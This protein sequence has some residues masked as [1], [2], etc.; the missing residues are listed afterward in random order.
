YTPVGDYADFYLGS[1]RTHICNLT[2]GIYNLR[3]FDPY[4]DGVKINENITIGL[5]DYFYIYTPIETQDCRLTLFN[6]DNNH[7]EFTDYHITVNRS[8][9]GVYDD[10]SLLDNLFLVDIETYIYIN[11]SDRF[12]T[13]IDTFERLSSDFIDLE[14]EVYSLQI[15]NIMEIKTTVD[16]NTTHIYPLLFGESVHFMLSKAYYQ[17]KFI[18]EYDY[19][20]NFTIYLDSNQAYQ[21]NSSLKTIYFSMFTYDGLGIDHDLVRFYINSERKDLGFNSMLKDTLELVILDFFNNTL[22]NETID[23]NAYDNSEYNLFVEIYSLVILNQFT[24]EDIVVNITQ[25]GSGVWMTQVIPKQF[26]LTYRFLPNVEYNITIYFTN[27]TLYTSKIINLTT[28]SHIESF[29]V[30]T[31]PEEYPKNIYFGVYTTTGLGI[32]R[33]LLRFYIDGNRTDFGFNR[34]TDMI[35]T[36]VVKDY[37][38]TTLFNQMINTSGIY[39]YDILI[40]LYSLKVKNEA[41]VTASYTLSYGVLGTSGYIF[42]EEIIEYQLS[43]NNYVFDYTNNEDGSFHTININL[44][45]DRVYI[46]NTTYYDVYIGLYNFYG[47]V[48]KEEVKFYIDGIRADFG[49]NTI[50]SDSVD[51]LVLDYFNSILYSQT[52]TL[53]GLTEYSIFIQAYTLV[54]N[55]LYNEKP[56]TIK[57]TRGS[58][59]IERLI[60]AQGWTE[61]KLYPNIRYDISSF[62][63]GTKDED[64][65]VDLKEEYTVVDFGFYE[66]EVPK[67]PVPQFLEAL[68]QWSMAI[69]FIAIVGIIGIVVYYKINSDKEK[70]YREMQRQIQ[71][72]R[73]KSFLNQYK[74]KRSK[75]SSRKKAKERQRRR[76]G[77]L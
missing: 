42:P 2:S 47:I 46:L 22:A 71:N 56:I 74:E 64:N 55:N 60:E 31:L 66:T 24:Y 34:I 5:S 51:L 18:D 23:A 38:N 21:L 43:S 67:Y 41:R 14:L 63:N 52:V 7:L 44:N 40:T 25:V 62:I 73:S 12:D 75:M 10:F 13:L 26:G 61:F 49:F 45:Q 54:V 37:F 32:D 48:N 28:N 77:L 11:V 29:G 15:K 20:K 9:N 36:I 65:D 16:I 69:V 33:D 8:L 17:I 27:T 53:Q 50:T 70:K 19:Y 1:K 6:T 68:V 39:E 30:A 3:I 59:T 76:S 35:I 4:N 57:I 72:P 58:I